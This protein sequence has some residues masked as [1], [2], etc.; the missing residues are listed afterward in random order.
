MNEIGK[1]NGRTDQTKD[2]IQQNANEIAGL[3]RRTDKSENDIKVLEDKTSENQNYIFLNDM[4]MM[5]NISSLYSRT[6]KLEE[7]AEQEDYYF[8]FKASYTK[9]VRGTNLKFPNGLSGNPNGYFDGEKF[10]AP[11]SGRYRFGLHL[12]I[13]RGEGP[14]YYNVHMQRSGS[15]DHYLSASG[16]R[17]SSYQYDSRHF[18]VEVDLQKNENIYFYIA[19]HSSGISYI[20]DSFMEGRLIQVQ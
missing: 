13:Y 3:T 2:N 15:T 7:I 1:L 12:Q 16:T 6:T 18:S 14:Y 20:S 10:N 17:H 5:G 8:K 11:I 9:M 4:E 19:V